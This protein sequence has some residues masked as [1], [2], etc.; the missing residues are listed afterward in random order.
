MASVVAFITFLNNLFTL[1][2]KLGALMQQQSFNDWMNSLQTTVNN[3]Q[4]AQT[5]EDRINAAKQL[6]TLTRNIH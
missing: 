3:L 2:T 1:G 4:N 6:A 5:D